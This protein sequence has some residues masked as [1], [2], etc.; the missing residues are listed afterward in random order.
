MN[1]LMLDLDHLLACHSQFLLGTWLESAKS[2]GRTPEEQQHY[3]WNARTMY[4]LW[5]PDF[6]LDD[7]SCRQWSGMFRT[8]YAKRWNLFY[9]ELDKSLIEATAWDRKAF[10]Q[11]LLT[12]QKAWGKETEMFP[13]KTSGENTLTIAKALLSKYEKEFE[14]MP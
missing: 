1:T 11:K 3:E 10:E 4:T 2:W 8:Y 12:F 7:Y 9:K 5:G 14:I 6:R 13:T